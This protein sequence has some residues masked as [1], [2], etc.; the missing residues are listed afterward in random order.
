MRF[1]DLTT[2]RCIVTGRKAEYFRGHVL[3]KIAGQKGPDAPV[4]IGAG[5]ASRKIA[6]AFRFGESG[7]AGEWKPKHGIRV[8]DS[9]DDE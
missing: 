5:F 7:Y 9:W 3:A 4:R 2:D 1:I 6:E 8:E